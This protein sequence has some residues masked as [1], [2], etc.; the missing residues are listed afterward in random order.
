MIPQRTPEQQRNFRNLYWDIFWIGVLVGTTLSFQGV[1]AARLGA[2]GFQVGLIGAGPALVGLL[3]TLP[4]GLWVEGRPLIRTAFFAAFWMRLGYLLLFLLPW[5]LGE[6]AQVWGLIALT[7]LVTLPA[8]LLNISFNALFANIVPPEWRG[9]VVAKRNALMAVSITLSTLVSGQILDRVAFPLNY[10]L[11]FLLGGI[12]AMISTV[13]VGK[14]FSAS[15]VAPLS[16]HWRE[17]LPAPAQ[18]GLRPAVGWLAALLFPPRPAGKALVRLDL[19]RGP[20]GLFMAAFLFFYT[21]QFF[22]NPLYPL[23]YVNEL[24]L[25]DS[26]IS[27]GTALFNAVMTVFSLAWVSK[28]AYRFGHRRLLIGSTLMSSLYA[29]L[30][31]LS[32]GPAW[33]W[34]ASLSTGGV[35]AV[36]NVSILNRLMERVPEDDRPAHM[37]LYNLAINIGILAGSLLGPLAGD[38][39]G[40]RPAMWLTV[41]MQVL[42][43]VFFWL[44]G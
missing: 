21:F 14:L 37:A 39:L 18:R 29:L 41:V 44:V 30:M 40:L 5:V 26:A 10:Q 25:S 6:Q 16:H 4:A 7:L 8:T 13:Y 17:L 2:S 11:V 27:L 42:S 3:Y 1:Y 38:W 20:F 36:M 9:E 19:L 23:F 35:W 24:N 32:D 28:M 22:P 15:E 43:A 12:G 31:A 33:F 34:L